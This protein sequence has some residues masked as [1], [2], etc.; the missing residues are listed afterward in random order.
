MRLEPTTHTRAGSSSAG[1][2]TEV[3]AVPGSTIRQRLSSQG[4]VWIDCTIT[5]ARSSWVTGPEGPSRSLASRPSW[6][7]TA[8][9]PGVV[10][11]PR[12]KVQW[13]SAGGSAPEDT[14]NVTP[15]WGASTPREDDASAVRQAS[16]AAVR[17]VFGVPGVST[18]T[19]CFMLSVAQ[20]M[21]KRLARRPLWSALAFGPRSD[22][23]SMAY[24]PLPESAKRVGRI[25]QLL[26]LIARDS[27]SSSS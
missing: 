1:S 4:S 18:T 3:P 15:S 12:L 10:G 14:T 26:P 8:Q 9:P 5:A 19:R 7:R 16:S 13:G 2:C 11:T 20:A 23:P 24:A 6:T 17:S 21:R 25:A 22:R 27:D